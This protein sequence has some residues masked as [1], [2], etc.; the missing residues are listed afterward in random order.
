MNQ[1]DPTLCENALFLENPVGLSQ[2]LPLSAEGVFIRNL[3]EKL[4]LQN[5]V[6]KG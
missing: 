3:H 4:I 6:S 1:D 5:L 2:H